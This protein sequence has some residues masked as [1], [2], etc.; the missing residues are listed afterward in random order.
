MKEIVIISGKG[1]TGKTSITASLA[2]IAKNNAVIADCDVDAADMHLLLAPKIEHKEDFYSG[3]LAKIDTDIC[4]L[5]NLCVEACRFDG[6]INLIDNK[7][8]VDEISCEGCAYCEKV[9][10]VDAIE[11][12]DAKAGDF[13]MSKTKIGNT[14][15]HAR[16]GIGADNS[17]KLVTKVKTEAKKTAQKNNIPYTII[18][19]TPGVG[20]PV[21]ASITGTNY[22]IIV[23]EPSQSGMHDMKRAFELVKKFNIKSA[24]IINKADINPKI[25]EEIKDF[26]KKNN[27][28]LLAELPYDEKFSE[29]ITAG[30]TI[31]EYDKNYHKIITEIWEKIKKNIN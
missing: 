2:I 5:C 30:Q 17:G 19:G 4:T 24:C 18:D 16:L 25:S 22:V 21:I 13:F 29:A 1:G 9:C 20:C 10:P 6:A 23:T 7:L 14:L 8:V 11:M 31:A 15:V 28:D 26:L 12:F 3:Q 27:I